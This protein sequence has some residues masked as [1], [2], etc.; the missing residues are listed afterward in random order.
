MLD[1]C[2]P[3]V[4][5]KMPEATISP[6]GDRGAFC[7]SVRGDAG[8]RGG[9]AC[10]LVDGYRV[11]FVARCRIWVLVRRAA[12][13]RAAGRRSRVG[14]RGFGLGLG[15]RGSRGRALVGA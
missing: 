3:A 11:T 13:A 2:Y 4:K 10:R 6:R 15:L 5:R 8:R 9:G 12:E 14:R 7:A 1:F